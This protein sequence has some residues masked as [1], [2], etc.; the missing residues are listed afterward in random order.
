MNNF[1]IAFNPQPLLD[2]LRK[3]IGPVSAN[4]EVYLN[5][6]V[7]DP[8]FVQTSEFAIDWFRPLPSYKDRFDKIDSHS[9][10][11]AGFFFAS[12]QAFEDGHRILAS[13]GQYYAL[14]HL[15]FSL[16][17]ID[18]STSDAVLQQIKHAK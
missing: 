2:S 18:F 11:S 5:R 10:I 14:F 8:N 9:V 4:L 3:S 6:V 17:A 16:V 7:S 12:R 15:T 1:D 13:I